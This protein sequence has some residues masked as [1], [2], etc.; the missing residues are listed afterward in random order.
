[1]IRVTYDKLTT[2]LEEI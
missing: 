2:N 1:M